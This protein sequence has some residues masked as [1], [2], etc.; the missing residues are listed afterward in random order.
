[1]SFTGIAH[2]IPAPFGGLTA[3][4]APTAGNGWE[5][6]ALSA[7]DYH[8]VLAVIPRM[9]NW[10]FAKM[11]ND[12]GSGTI[13][14]N[15]D[16]TIYQSSFILGDGTTGNNLLD[17]ECIWQFFLNGNL[18]FD[19]LGETIQDVLVDP[20]EQRNSQI[21]GPGTAQTLSWALAMPQG[22]PNVIQKTDTIADSFSEVDSNGNPLLDTS[23][24]NLAGPLADITFSAVGNFSGLDLAAS[25]P[26]A[27]TQGTCILTATAG[28]TVLAG[29]P[30][31]IT[32][33]IISAEVDAMNVVSTPSLDGSQV[34][35]MY[36]Q[37]TSN[38]NHYAL[39][40]LSSTE[41]YC[42]LGDTTGTSTKVLGTYDP[43][44]DAFWMITEESGYFFF[45]SSADGTTW[46]LDWSAPYHWDA[47]SVDVVFAAIYD[48]SG[49]AQVGIS[50]INQN[51]S[52]P[53]TQ[54]NIF[55]NQSV[56]AMW[57]SLL[58]TAQARGT[59]P[60]VTTRLNATNDS[61]QNPW[62]DSQ[63]AQ[64][65]NGTDLFSLLQQ[66]C[67]IAN[68]DFRMQPGFN[69]QVGLQISLTGETSLGIDYSKT[70]IF[71]EADRILTK[72][73]TR[74]RDNIQ[75]LVA[76]VNQDGTIVTAEDSS[77]ITT[78]QQ[79]EGWVTTGNQITEEGMEI[80]AAASV[81]STSDEVLQWTVT[82]Q[83]DKTGCVPLQDFDVGDWIGMERPGGASTIDAVRVVGIAYS[84]DQDG[85]ITCE[86]TLVGYRQWLDEQLTYLVNKFGGNFINSLG[87]SL[88]VTPATVQKGIPLVANPALGSL[89]DVTI[90]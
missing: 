83:P 27:S 35:Q 53:T 12:K 75:N 18:V 51:V 31:D 45:F 87:S 29:G 69:L 39:I 38:A 67:A 70:I 86:L 47:T 80:V 11:L 73:R 76:A 40:G 66:T 13:Q 48:T 10:Q 22:F 72:G 81:A 41:F 24:W 82:V 26:F 19:Y 64:I 77:S 44:N 4:P 15:L 65:P 50:N 52:V 5:V 30:F 84:A 89:T 14:V 23:L 33:S 36:V 59:I 90:D 61:F 42:Q 46:V 6:K 54:G 2:S 85:L 7:T 57:Y 34:T 79:R 49:V 28:G 55:L 62:T 88:L 3:P 17:T 74:T 37:S 58:T 25:N 1:M 43:N 8:T 60:F 16:D 20:S 32:N 71:H 68:A 56:M 9:E 21:T 78:W 63:S